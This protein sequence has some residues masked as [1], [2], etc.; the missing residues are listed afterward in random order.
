LLLEEDFKYDV[1]GNLVEEDVTQNST[2]TTTRYAVDAWNPAKAGAL[3]VS[4]FD[5]WA[6]LNG[7]N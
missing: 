4:G 7:S 1:Y 2:T 6:E 3:G 5:V